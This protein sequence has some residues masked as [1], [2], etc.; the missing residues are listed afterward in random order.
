[1]TH[2]KV[3][4]LQA[5]TL[6]VEQLTLHQ[7]DILLCA[8]LKYKE[9]LKTHGCHSQQ[10]LTQALIESKILPDCPMA[11]LLCLSS[12]LNLQAKLPFII[13]GNDITQLSWHGLKRRVLDNMESDNSCSIEDRNRGMFTLSHWMQ[14]ATLTGVSRPTKLPWKQVSGNGNVQWIVPGFKP[15]KLCTDF[16][17]SIETWGKPNNTDL[18]LQMFS[19]APAIICEAPIRLQPIAATTHTKCVLNKD[20]VTIIMHDSTESVNHVGS[21]VLVTA[22]SLTRV[23]CMAGSKQTH[24]C[25]VTQSRLGFLRNYNADCLNSLGAWARIAQL[26]E[27]NKSCLSAQAYFYLQTATSAN[28]TIGNSPLCA[29]SEFL[30]SWTNTVDREGWTRQSNKKQ[31]PIIFITAMSDSDQQTSLEWLNV[32]RPK[33]WYILARAKSCSTIVKRELLIIGKIACRLKRGLPLL[34][35]AGSWRTG[36]IRAS[37][38]SDDWELWVAKDTQE[39]QLLNL[40][41]QIALMPLT[42]SGKIPLSKSNRI[43]Q[44]A[45]FG[46]AGK[47]YNWQAQLLPQMAQY[48]QMGAWAALQY[49]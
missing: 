27:A 34:A 17:F 1:M 4:L 3:F 44:E 35:R 45:V 48:E 13:T 8:Q 43:M 21:F 32:A 41:Q 36:D 6:H 29:S 24:V 30:S 11:R 19:P 15:T 2:P 20:F 31:I 14:A 28:L 10:E 39:D 23:D 26:S 25:T 49:S 46:P 16:S 9:M 18:E 37:K 33:P 40:E 47:Y 7:D 22:R 12:N 38:S 42:S 5:L